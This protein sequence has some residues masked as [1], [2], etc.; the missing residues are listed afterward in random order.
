MLNIH[1]HS[2]Y[3]DYLMPSLLWMKLRRFPL[4]LIKFH[5]KNQNKTASGGARKCL[6]KTIKPKAGSSAESKSWVDIKRPNSIYTFFSQSNARTIINVI[7][8]CNKNKCRFSK[9][10]LRK[11]TTK[12]IT[13]LGD[14]FFCFPFCRND[15]VGKAIRCSWKYLKHKLQYGCQVSNYWLGRYSNFKPKTEK[16]LFLFRF[17]KRKRKVSTGWN[18]KIWV[19]EEK[20]LKG[21]WL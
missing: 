4:N 7:K 17:K 11:T 13:L 8:S 5:N 6:F 18:R 14:S 1:L 21:R 20:L 10:D 3:S 16:F 9:W 15:G 12:M 19:N 2:H